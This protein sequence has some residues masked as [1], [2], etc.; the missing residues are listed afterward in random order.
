[1]TNARRAA[2]LCLALG[3]WLPALHL[4]F[5]P[6]ARASLV[7]GLAARQR[8]LAL[9]DDTPPRRLMRKLN[10]EW[11]LMSR[12]FAV[13]AFT[14]L[15]LA[16]PERRAAHLEVADALI[17][18]TLRDEARGPLHF[19]LPYGR[20]APFLDPGQRSLFVDGEVAL[21][22]AARQHVE[23]RP[24][25]SPL[26]A[27]RVDEVVRQ[28]EG[29]PRLFA[30]SYPDEGWTFCNSIAVA[31]LHLSDRLDG[32]DHAPLVARFLASMKAHLV[33]PRTGL[34]IASFRRD[35]TPL[36]GPEGSTLWL[37]AHMLQLVDPPF[38]DDQYRRARAALGHTALGFGWASEWPKALA[39]VADVDSGPTIPL[40]DANAGSSGLALLG[41]AAFDDEPFLEALVTSLELAAFPV[42]DETGLR[43]A[44]GNQLGDAVL[45]YALTEGP[46]WQRAARSAP[47]SKRAAAVGP[48]VVEVVSSPATV[49]TP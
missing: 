24:D 45:L 47:A 42:R 39:N 6:P 18:Q 26:L 4:V 22:L 38:A 14:N 12:T 27:A 28:L 15:A 29:S 25:F 33:E 41:A 8:Q 30:E 21:M 10:P 17:R 2:C 36:D 5:R 46:L 11:D 31:A 23:V 34:L 1:M 32:R 13:L 3:L 16:Q 40:V 20:R 44:A 35:A 48:A 7:E 9:S 19:L 43:Y 49:S 37:A